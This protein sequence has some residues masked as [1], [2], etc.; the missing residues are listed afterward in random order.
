MSGGA[1]GLPDA[2]TRR[3][4]T[5]LLSPSPC[6]HKRGWRVLGHGSESCSL[7]TRAQPLSLG[8]VPM[9]QS[10]QAGPVFPGRRGWGRTSSSSVNGH[11][12]AVPG[13]WNRPTGWEDTWIGPQGGTVVFTIR[14]AALRFHFGEAVAPL[15]R[16]GRGIKGPAVCARPPRCPLLPGCVS[17]AGTPPSPGTPPALAPP[18]APAP[19][20]ALS[21]PQHWHPP[22]ISV[23]VDVTTGGLLGGDHSACPSVTIVLTEHSVLKPR[24][25]GRGQNVPPEGGVVPTVPMDRAVC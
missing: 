6:G 24:P 2:G 7:V 3:P 10:T 22:P 18:P 11:D 8:H 1:W 12:S 25:C 5:W 4:L 21:P 9:A 23:S 16:H 15:I 20:P 14:G 13:T 17:A 19:L